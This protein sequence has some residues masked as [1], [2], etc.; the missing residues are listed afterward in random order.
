MFQLISQ[1]RGREGVFFI[2][3]Q[4][5]EKALQVRLVDKLTVTTHPEELI[6]VRRRSDSLAIDLY[7]LVDS[8]YRGIRNLVVKEAQVGHVGMSTRFIIGR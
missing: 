4:Q 8:V 3:S 6:Q 5:V 2:S 7:A 1:L